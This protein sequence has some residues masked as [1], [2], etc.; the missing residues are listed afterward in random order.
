MSQSIRISNISDSFWFNLDDVISKYKL[1]RF[2]ITKLL[3]KKG[4]K[5]KDGLKYVDQSNLYLVRRKT[6]S[7]RSGI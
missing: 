2:G 4:V 3:D 7:F 6:P 1:S 5:E